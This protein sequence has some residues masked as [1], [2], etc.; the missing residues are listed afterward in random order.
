[1]S[2]TNDLLDE[3]LAL[4]VEQ[5]ALLADSILRSL[6]RPDVGMDHMWAQEAERR[7]A[8]LRSGKVKP[9][10]CEEVFGKIKARFSK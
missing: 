6:N 5:R 9:I 4:P 10:P 8:D 1:M 7:L 3:A 2:K